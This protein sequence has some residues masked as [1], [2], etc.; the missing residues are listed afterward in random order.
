MPCTNSPPSGTRSPAYCNWPSK[1]GLAQRP[2]P[3]CREPYQAYNALHPAPSAQGCQSHTETAQEGEGQRPGR[4]H[5]PARKL[6]GRTQGPAYLPPVPDWSAQAAASRT[7][8]RR[9]GQ[10]RPTEPTQPGPHDAYHLPVT[11][12]DGRT[13]SYFFGL[14]Q[15]P[16]GSKEVD[17]STFWFIYDGDASPPPPIAAD[18]S[19]PPTQPREQHP[20]LPMSCFEN[21]RKSLVRDDRTPS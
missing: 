20:P 19:C 16:R 12:Y 13:W 5:Q 6:G 1:K 3:R 8:Q 18:A 10:A 9:A 17:W 7:A 15:P 2:T 4:D 11:Q 21:R 14:G